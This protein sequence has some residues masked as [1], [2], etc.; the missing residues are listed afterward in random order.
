MVLLGTYVG[1]VVVLMIALTVATGWGSS[2]VPAGSRPTPACS[3]RIAGVVM[4]AAGIGQLY[5]A[6]VVFELH[7][8]IL[9]LL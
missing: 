1:T 7:H 8:A 2:P 3:K 9:E 5:L 4:I 6:I